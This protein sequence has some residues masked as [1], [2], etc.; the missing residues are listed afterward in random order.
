MYLKVSCPQL[1]DGQF[2]Y[3]FRNLKM[4][5]IKVISKFLL[6][7]LLLSYFQFLPV[8]IQPSFAQEAGGGIC[9]SGE[10]DNTCVVTAQEGLC[11]I[12]SRVCLPDGI[13]DECKQAYFPK[14]EVCDDELDNDCDGFIDKEDPDCQSSEFALKQPVIEIF[15]DKGVLNYRLLN[16]VEYAGLDAARKVDWFEKIQLEDGSYEKKLLSSENKY[17]PENSGIYLIKFTIS[18]QTEEGEIS[19]SAE[20][21]FVVNFPIIDQTQFENLNYRAGERFTLKYFDEPGHIVDLIVKIGEE[22]I[23]IKKMGETKY[24][25]FE[26]AEIT[27]SGGYQLSINAKSEGGFETKFTTDFTVSP[28]EINSASSVFEMLQNGEEVR[29]IPVNS[30]IVKV[31]FT[32]YDEYLNGIPVSNLDRVD[33]RHNGELLEGADLIGANKFTVERLFTVSK[34]EDLNAVVTVD[35]FDSECEGVLFVNDQKIENYCFGRTKSLVIYD[36]YV[37]PVKNL[38]Y[39]EKTRE[40]N[41]TIAGEKKAGCGIKINSANA[42]FTVNPD[43]KTSFSFTIPLAEG[44]NSVK[45][46]AVKVVTEELTFYSDPV[47]IVVGKDNKIIPPVWNEPAVTLDG[48]NQATLHW[49]DPI[50][51]TDTD[52]DFSHVNIYRSTVPN[53]VPGAENLVIQTHNPSWTDTGLTAGVKYYYLIE[54]VDNVG[55]TAMINKVQA[56]GT[57]KGDSAETG[58]ADDNWYDN[59]F[60]GKGT[61]DEGSDEGILSDSIEENEEVE[62]ETT[63]RE[64]TVTEESVVDQDAQDENEEGWLNN[65][66]TKAG[67]SLSSLYGK[68]SNNI[69]VQICCGGIIIF[70]ALMILISML[71]W[72]KEKFIDQSSVANLAEEPSENSQSKKTSA[73]PKKGR[74]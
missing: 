20:D 4:K 31:R 40:G 63:G 30:G 56:T 47:E 60:A 59:L 50:Y 27:K 26:G 14:L 35:V 68:L 15:A 24:W 45:I 66:F 33:I 10:V 58:E 13:W 3:I 74:G 52:F 39:P 12:G 7:C 72:L 51:L 1:L 55:N 44:L 37:S 46:Y 19:L 42:G 6:V 9:V 32:A 65:L 21:E 53:F 62:N 61:Y 17:V 49:T 29:Y 36:E 48:D 11:S 34:Q 16:Q 41:I 8:F 5:E 2:F 54:A 73:K 43:D 64:E 67:N 57:I 18:V 25:E 70:V 28:N 71:V 23:N 22:D 38:E 69:F